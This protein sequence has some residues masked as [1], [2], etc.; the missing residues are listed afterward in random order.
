M[1]MT[2]ERVTL[3]G[4]VPLFMGMSFIVQGGSHKSSGQK[5]LEFFQ[6]SYTT[7]GEESVNVTA[8]PDKVVQ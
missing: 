5:R 6:Q 1:Q 3:C 7:T 2:V 4:D 8:E